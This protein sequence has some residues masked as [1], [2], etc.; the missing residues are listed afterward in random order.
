MDEWCNCYGSGLSVGIG[1]IPMI[2]ST[3]HPY[4]LDTLTK[5]SVSLTKRHFSNPKLYFF[6]EFP[7]K[8]AQD[9]WNSSFSAFRRWAKAAPAHRLAAAARGPAGGL[10]LGPKSQRLAYE[11][12]GLTWLRNDDK[13]GF[14]LGDVEVFF[15]FCFFLTILYLTIFSL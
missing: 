13:Y 11:N 1:C 10:C 3:H 8:I 4:M 5:S 6:H 14:V 7:K 2:S 12:M 9:A 15:C